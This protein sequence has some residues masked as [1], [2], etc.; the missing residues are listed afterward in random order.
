M[1]N[2]VEERPEVSE[3][4]LFYISEDLQYAADPFFHALP[5][6]HAWSAQPCIK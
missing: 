4:H 1:K 6:A 5:E 3:N 2:P